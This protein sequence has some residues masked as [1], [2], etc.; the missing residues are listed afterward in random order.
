MSLDDLYRELILDHY[1]NPRNFGRLPEANTSV[2]LKNPTCGDE[3]D[4]QLLVADGR[5]VRAAF[6]GQGCSIS[7]A[8]ASM[9]TEA[10]TGKSVE[11]ARA[12]LEDFERMMHGEAVLRDM[13]DLA[14]LEGVARF[15]VRIK[16]ALLAWEGLD[17]SLKQIVNP[18]GK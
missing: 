5:I 18:A 13:G 10:I 1:R 16:C 2:H 8:S 14:S 17:K 4:L 11:E 15:P 6:S 3:I 9:M 7:Q 12:I